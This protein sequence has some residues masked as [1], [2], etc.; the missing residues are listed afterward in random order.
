MKKEYIEFIENYWLNSPQYAIGKCK[1]MSELMSMYFPE[2]KIVHGI[3]NGIKNNVLEEHP[4][5]WLI[6]K[7]NNIIDPT[8]SQFCD[9]NNIIYKQE[10]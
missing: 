10:N 6:D 2:L 1:M 8:K 3:V 4:H 5:W 7:E 9:L